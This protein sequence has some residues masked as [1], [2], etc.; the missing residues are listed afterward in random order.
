MINRPICEVSVEENLSKLHF[1][2]RPPFCFH[3]FSLLNNP[4][5]QKINSEFQKLKNDRRS[6]WVRQIFQFFDLF[7]VY[8]QS[9]ILAIE[10]DTK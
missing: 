8:G 6:D 1:P 5:S 2:L 4:I 10:I 7:S 3:N 9:N